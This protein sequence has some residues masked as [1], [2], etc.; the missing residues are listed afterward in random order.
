[1]GEAV[2]TLLRQFKQLSAKERSEYLS[3]SLSPSG[4]YGNWNND[5][6]VFFAAQSFAC[7]DADRESAASS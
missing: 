7:L 4:N 6:A 2:V 5:D 3:A 1:M